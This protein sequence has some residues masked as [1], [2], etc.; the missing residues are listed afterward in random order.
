MRNK[1]YIVILAILLAFSISCG[2]KKPV[3]VEDNSRPVKVQ[4]LENN[5]MSLGYTASGTIKG[6]EE[7][8]YTATASGEVIVINAKNGDNVQSGQVIVSI[9]NQS[10]RSGVTS[11][12]SNV[13]MA[14][15]GIYEAEDAIKSAQNEISAAQN[16]ISSAQQSINNAQQEISSAEADVQSAQARIDSAS[17]AVEEARINF[18]KYQTLYDKRLITETEYLSARSALSSAEANLRTMRNNYT[19]AINI[20][21]SKKNNLITQRNNLN[22]KKTNLDSKRNNL[23][24][25][26]TNLNS[27]V[28]NLNSARANLATAQDTNKKTIISAKRNGVIA[29]MS[30]EQNQQVSLGT[31]L[32]TIIDDSEMKIEVGVSPQVIEK[33]TKGSEARVKIDELGGE[34]ITG[35]VYEIS[36]S[37]NSAT[38]QFTVKIKIPNSERRIKSGMYGTVNINTGVEQG[39]VIPKSSIVIRG[40]EQVVYIVKDGV[41]VAIPI[42]ISNQNEQYAAVIGEGLTV[43]SELIVDG[44]N[45]IQANDKVKKVQ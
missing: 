43:G 12:T 25:K 36:S 29:N 3:A 32:F 26:R 24:S 21:N 1:K 30:L 42:Q 16:E 7:T 4:I 9:D 45:V 39:I 19:T 38:R 14:Q 44:Q 31:T 41:A 33:I 8:P 10:A 28:S 17:I 20:L 37:A 2:K 13:E 23:N 15:A 6:I 40:V 35:S 11:A 18:E 5:Q 27:K 34:E 22:S